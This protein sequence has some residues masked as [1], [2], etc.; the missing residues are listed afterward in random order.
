MVVQN[1]RA[2]EAH[3]VIKIPLLVLN[4]L[5]LVDIKAVA[6]HLATTLLLIII[7]GLTLL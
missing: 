7:I 2:S 6:N 1:G 5:A 3:M 4:L